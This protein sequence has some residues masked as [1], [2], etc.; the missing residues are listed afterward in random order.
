MSKMLVTT[1]PEIL[2]CP[3][4]R[5][6]SRPT[7]MSR[8]VVHHDRP[9]RRD[10]SVERESTLQFVGE[11]LVAIASWYL[12]F[13]AGVIDVGKKLVIWGAF[14]AL[15]WFLRDFFGLLFLTFILGFI[16]NNLV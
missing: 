1:I 14:F 15:L 7:F 6:M 3:P 2:F 16:A 9:A 4:R 10:R 13:S 12:E 8:S 5:G 11:K